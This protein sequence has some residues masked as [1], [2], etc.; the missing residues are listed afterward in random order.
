MRTTGT[1]DLS[2]RLME[3]AAGR[4]PARRY[5]EGATVL[6]VYSG[7]LYGAN[8]AIAE[9]RVAYVGP[10][11]AMV[12]DETD[13]VPLAGRVLVPGYVDPHTH[14]TGMLHPVEFARGVLP[15]GTTAVVADTLHILLQTPPALVA[16]LLER[17]AAMPVHVYWFLRP[18]A[19]SPLPDETMFA[20]DRLAPLLGL[21]VVRALG[22]VTPWPRLFHGDEDLFRK[23]ALA[24]AAG[25]RIEGHAPGA[26]Y[27]RLAA[28]AAAGWSADHEAIT[29]DEALARLRAGIYTMLRHS[30]LR[31]DMPALAAAVTR[32]RLATGRL[33]LT[34]DAPNVATVAECGYMDHVIRQAIAAGI[35]PVSAYQMA[36]L[37]P[38]SYFGLDE[39]IGGIAPGRMADI[40]VLDDLRNPSPSL[41]LAAGEVAARE[42]AAI[43]PFPEV[44]WDRY[45]PRRFQA[46]WD[47]VPSIFETRRRDVAAPYQDEHVVFPVMHLENSVITR[48]RDVRVPVRGDVL[49]WPADVVRLALVDPGGRWVTN[50]ALS[51]FAARLDALASSFN[52]MAH[53]SVLGQSPRDMALATRRLLELGGGIVAV[54]GGASVLEIPLPIGGVMSRDDLATAAGR[55]RQLSAFLRTRGYPHTDPYYTLLFLPIDSLPDLRVTY[56]GVW[57]VR[58][59]RVL[60]PRR[61]L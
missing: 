46:G 24:R 35:P 56:H 1:A 61:D 17:L 51:N 18:S 43:V 7:E 22:E 9:G 27:D 60:V 38:A 32:E 14:I 52:V 28:L 30:S 59:E 26:S 20:E 11:R 15:S 34:T 57:D 45:F 55:V 6:N 36:T 31:P 53:A 39:E 21:H 50:G 49:E 12:G 23:I 29:A 58:R 3:V 44:D 5:L 41:V 37:N 33:M 40:A 47:P 4:R 19:A 2:R 48:R 25:R 10:S 13:V 8:V 16:E 54:E 42:G